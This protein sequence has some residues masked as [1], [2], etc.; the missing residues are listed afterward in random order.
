MGLRK[1]PVRYGL[2][3]EK[4][5]DLLSN[6]LFFVFAAGLSLLFGHYVF[7]QEVFLEEIDYTKEMI[8]LEQNY[9]QILDYEETQRCISYKNEEKTLCDVYEPVI[10]YLYKTNTFA[11]DDVISKNTRQLDERTYQIY[12]SDAFYQEGTNWVLTEFGI[13][14]KNDF[15]AFQ[16]DQ[17]KNVG[18]IISRLNPLSIYSVSA[19]WYSGNGDGEIYKQCDG[20]ANCKSATS[21]TADNTSVSSLNGWYEAGATDE[22]HR[23]FLPFETSS[24][25]DDI[26]IA[27]SSVYVYQTS[28]YSGTPEMCL[29]PSSQ[30]SYTSLTANDYDNWTATKASDCPTIQQTK[31]NAF[32]LNDVG[33]TSISTTGYTPF[34]FLLEQDIDNTLLSANQYARFYLSEQAGTGN[35]PYILIETEDCP[36]EPEGDTD[37]LP[38]LPFVNDL[39]V[40][41]GITQHYETSSTS[42]DWYEYHY[43]RIPFIVWGIIAILAIWLGSRLVL[44]F[45]IRFRK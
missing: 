19:Q 44:E 23:Q 2:V 27:S 34:G 14:E 30:S 38:D 43:Y 5:T 24:L 26:C 6:G 10:K 3:K 20:W 25:D 17:L 21:G 31:Y 1:R 45:L 35:D 11:P 15:E 13:S 8:D 33:T 32:H 12:A 9:D 39:S 22:L 18:E 7:A 36:V 4:I 41:T 29:V 37:E 40:I 28:S 42:P 16:A